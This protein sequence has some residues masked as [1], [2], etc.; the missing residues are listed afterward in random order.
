MKTDELMSPTDLSEWLGIPV[1][2]IYNWRYASN[3]PPGFKIGKHVRYRRSEVE[4]WFEQHRDA[5]PPATP[6][7]G[8]GR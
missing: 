6:P 8:S 7:F 4:K 2:T 5:A 3:G 1:T